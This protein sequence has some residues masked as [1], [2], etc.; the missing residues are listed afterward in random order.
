MSEETAYFESLPEEVKQFAKVGDTGDIKPVGQFAADITDAFQWMGNSVRLPGPDA[1]DDDKAGFRDKM[2]ERFDGLTVTPNAEDPEAMSAH[3]ARIGRPDNADAY[4]AP[5]NVQIEGDQLGQLKSIA[6]KANLTQAQF[7]D[8]LSTMTEVNK[9]A[10]GAAA[11]Q[12]EEGLATLKG[13]WGAAY[14]ERVGQIAAFLKTNA[15]TPPGIVEQLQ[16]GN[17]PAD[18]VRWLHSLADAV[19][20][21]DGQFHQ[22]GD[23][24]NPAIL[25]KATAEHLSADVTARLAEPDLPEAERAILMKKSEAYTYM[26]MGQRPP[27]ELLRYVA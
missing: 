10:I 3:F 5:D 14:D 1:S 7:S 12:H 26:K 23:G 27:A 25:D 6:F 9:A 20:N 13:E 22:Q 24:D 17:L 19:S 16:Q 21:E 8:Y 2:L 18:Q 4:K 11:L 15:T